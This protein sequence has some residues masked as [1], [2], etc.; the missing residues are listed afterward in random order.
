MMALHNARPI[1]P[2]DVLAK[3]RAPVTTA[4]SEGLHDAWARTSVAFRISPVSTPRLR[5]ATVLTL[6]CG[7]DAKS[8][9]QEDANDDPHRS[10]LAK[11][12]LRA[13]T[14]CPEEEADGESRL[15]GA[16]CIDDETGNGGGDDLSDEV[17]D[18]HHPCHDWRV[19]EHVLEIQ[20]RHVEVSVH[21]HTDEP[22]LDE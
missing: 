10:R 16:R 12:D 9:K 20:R 22:C 18:H 6:E 1:A 13:L 21:D 19:A 4:R 11:A 15:V 8:L 5:G 17:W 2:P 3:L 7:T 14:R